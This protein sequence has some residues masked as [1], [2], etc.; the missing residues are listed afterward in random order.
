[1]CVE[2]NV[3]NVAGGQG[4]SGWIV[5]VVDASGVEKTWH[6]KESGFYR[7][8]D[9]QAGSTTVTV[10]VPAGWR[11]VSPLPASLIAAPGEACVNVDIWAEQADSGSGSEPSPEPTP[12]R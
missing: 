6:T 4:L 11:A 5:R 1:M 2:G 8:G 7:F 9:L 12:L 10:D 3:L